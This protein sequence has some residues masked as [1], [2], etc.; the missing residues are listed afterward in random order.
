VLELEYS[1]IPRKTNT[2]SKI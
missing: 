1:W 2:R